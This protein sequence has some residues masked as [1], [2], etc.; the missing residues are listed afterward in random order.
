[1]AWQTGIN[2]AGAAASRVL[3]GEYAPW[4]GT[5]LFPY[6]WYDRFFSDWL[7]TLDSKIEPTAQGNKTVVVQPGTYN[8]VAAVSSGYHATFEAG[9]GNVGR[10]FWNFILRSVGAA[11]VGAIDGEQSDLVRA[12]IFFRQHMV[13][14]ETLQYVLVTL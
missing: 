3:K 8:L 2:D 4:A 12:T 1:M 5:L 14:K 7:L 13:S 6:L 10:A 9:L 11:P